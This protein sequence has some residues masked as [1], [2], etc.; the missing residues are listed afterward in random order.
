MFIPLVGLGV[1]IFAVLFLEYIFRLEE[2]RGQRFGKK[3]RLHLDYYLLKTGNGITHFFRYLRFDLLKQVSRY[4]LHTFFG[5]LLQLLK[6]Q[7]KRVHAWQRR[8]RL[9]ARESRIERSTKNKLDEIAEH[10]IA[11]ALTDKE[12]KVWRQK[13][14]EGD[15]RI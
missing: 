5:A 15:R 8:N 1:S 14:L 12:K 3:V 6:Q 4:M 10:K 7:E 2:K 13:T 11:V 9:R